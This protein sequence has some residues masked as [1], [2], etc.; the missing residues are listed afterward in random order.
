MSFA[1]GLDEKIYENA[2]L[3]ELHERGLTTNQQQRFPVHFKRQLVGTLVPDLI[4]GGKVIVDLKVAVAF[5]DQHVSQMLGYLAITGLDLAIL[6]N[7]RSSK[8]E[9][10]RVLHPRLSAGVPSDGS[11]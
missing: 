5:N 9:W 11:E 4:V 3:I 6:I 7:F 10:K 2:L 1:P 8:I